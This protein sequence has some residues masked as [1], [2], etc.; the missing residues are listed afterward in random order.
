ME[1]CESLE[2]GLGG[3]QH[4]SDGVRLREAG[5]G[6]STDRDSL[7]GVVQ[8]VETAAQLG[9]EILEFPA[10][11]GGT[12]QDVGNHAFGM[13]PSNADRIR[14]ARWLTSIPA[15]GVVGTESA[16]PH[17]YPPAGSWANWRIRPRP[18][19]ALAAA[20]QRHVRG[21]GH[22][23]RDG[24]LNWLRWLAADGRATGRFVGRER[25]RVDHAGRRLGNAGELDRGSAFR[26]ASAAPR[27]FILGVQCA[28]AV[29][30]TDLDRHREIERSY[31]I[32]PALA[33]IVTSVE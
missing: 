1:G 24:W 29:L 13:A 11:R 26:A 2:E 27:Q 5:N 25:W 23:R 9:S 21:R 33:R 17:R 12:L 14:A 22:K 19:H 28:L 20:R 31:L 15:A 3:L 4:F 10:D 16:R 32:T 7:L 30:A 18:V 8:R 6:V